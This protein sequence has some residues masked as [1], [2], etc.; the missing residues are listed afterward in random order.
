MQVVFSE[1]HRLHDP[2]AQVEAGHR[3]PMQETPSRAEQI[4]SS[5]A[6][7]ARFEIVEP[8]T[9]GRAPIDSVHE[10]AMVS[11]IEHAHAEWSAA[12]GFDIAIP[13]VFFHPAL[14][15][16]M[17]PIADAESPLGRLGYWCF[18]TTTPI[19]AG[20]YTAARSAVDSALTAT[21]TVLGGASNAYALCRPPGHHAAT[22]VF[23]GYCFFNN[24][25]IAAQ[26]AV[27]KGAERVAV[28]DVDYHHGN[29]TEQIFYERPDVFYASL[30]GDPA[31]A[32][33]Y[34][35]GFADETGT[36]RG[37]GRN[38][39]IP[40]E[41]GCENDMYLS[42]LTRALDAI[43]SYN[44]EVLFVSLGLDIFGGDPLGDLA[45]TTDGI[46]RIGAAIRARS[47]PTV[48]LQEG[49]YAVSELGNNAHAF[50][51]K[52]VSLSS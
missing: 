20:T 19:V 26:H 40:L 52:F 23:G 45:I 7:D 48:I 21:D 10:P 13:D 46:G 6:Q 11:Y 31:R 5:L 35:L 49:G 47:M 37:N 39:N 1:S 36:G 2:T 43:D 28:L 42:E 17:E 9:F 24:A 12:S 4:I 25:A 18:E 14:R 8:K 34:F 3:I 51:D 38:L 50:L 29:G 30:H 44:P 22:S 32:Y 15:A 41:A 33:P 16:G 27:A